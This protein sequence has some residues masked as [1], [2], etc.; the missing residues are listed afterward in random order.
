MVLALLLLVV[1]AFGTAFALL[2]A[3]MR[4]GERSYFDNTLLSWFR[5]SQSPTGLIG[6]PWLAET[7]R[8]VTSLGSFAILS[9]I[10]VLCAAVPAAGSTAIRSRVCRACGH[11]W[12][13]T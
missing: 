4:E 6:P 8:D 3:E 7:A 10:I 11:K 1:L 9:I 13:D 2:A 12:H 5:N